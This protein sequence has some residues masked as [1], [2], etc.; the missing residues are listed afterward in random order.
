MMRGTLEKHCLRVEQIV[1]NHCMAG[2]W[3]PAEAHVTTAA[4]F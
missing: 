3:T 4:K 1:L 2:F